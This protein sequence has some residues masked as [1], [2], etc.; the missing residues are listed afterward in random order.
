MNHTNEGKPREYWIDPLLSPPNSVY[1]EP[2][3][4]CIHVIEYSAFESAQA[5]IKELEAQLEIA[6]QALE[7]YR[8]VKR[9]IMHIYGGDYVL[10][11]DEALSKLKGDV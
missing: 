8:G 6:I 1:T 4:S 11:A 9:V 2:S 3:E 10:V 7:K 5:R